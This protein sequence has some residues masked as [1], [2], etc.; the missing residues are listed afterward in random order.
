LLRAAS[1]R[2]ERGMWL[3]AGTNDGAR[4]ARAGWRDACQAR[5]CRVHALRTV[6]AG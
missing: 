2:V 1:G 4:L 6:P 5:R 3:K